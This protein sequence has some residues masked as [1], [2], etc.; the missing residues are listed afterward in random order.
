MWFLKLCRTHTAIDR[1]G[2]LFSVVVLTAMSLQ[3]YLVVCTRWRYTASTTLTTLI[4]II[5]GILAC[6]V[7]PIVWEIHY[8]KT[9]VVNFGVRLK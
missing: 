2:K 8:T 4:P 5:V 1:G 6:V 9:I 7:V 3:R